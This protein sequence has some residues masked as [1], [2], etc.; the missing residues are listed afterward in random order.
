MQK[1][2]KHYLA[3]LS[4]NEN[5]QD[6]NYPQLKSLYHIQGLKTYKTQKLPLL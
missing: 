6:L 1:V 2:T 3:L 4:F 5:V